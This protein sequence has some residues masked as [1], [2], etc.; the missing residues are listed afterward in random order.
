MKESSNSIFSS[1]PLLYKA[2][3]SLVG[4]LV[5]S[6]EFAKSVVYFSAENGELEHEAAIPQWVR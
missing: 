5:T 4:V 2:S 1:I 6:S 3:C